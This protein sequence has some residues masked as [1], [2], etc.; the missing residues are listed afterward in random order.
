MTIA[1]DEEHCGWASAIGYPNVQT[2]LS[3]TCVLRGT[4]RLLGTHLTKSTTS[5]AATQ[6]FDCMLGWRGQNVSVSSIFLIGNLQEWQGLRNRWHSKVVKIVKEKFACTGPVYLF[7]TWVA[8]KGASVTVQHIGTA[9]PLC[10][11]V[12]RDEY[13]YHTNGVTGEIKRL[14]MRNNAPMMVKPIADRRIELTG[15]RTLIQPHKF[16]IL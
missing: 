16:T 6:I 8:R 15:V 4:D 3:I 5:E 13:V 9:A 1:L 12:G 7:D 2:C 14:S 11:Y 10:D